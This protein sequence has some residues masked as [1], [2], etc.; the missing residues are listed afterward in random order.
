MDRFDSMAYEDTKC[1]CGGKKLRET[2][3]CDDCE[4]HVADRVEYKIMHDLSM[5]WDS[6]RSAAVRLIGLAR[7]R[8]KP[9]RLALEYV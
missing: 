4:V 2:M 5:S 7:K 6:R 8:T 3:L 1:P 9:H